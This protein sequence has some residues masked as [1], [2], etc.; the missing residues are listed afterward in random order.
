MFFVISFLI[1]TLLLFTLNTVKNIMLLAV[2]K[3]NTKIIGAGL[4]I[5]LILV[6]WNIAAIILVLQ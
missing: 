4:F 6:S 1:A 3:E 2:D 5:A